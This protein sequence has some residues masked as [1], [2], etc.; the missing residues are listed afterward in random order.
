MYFAR[1]GCGCSA[2][3]LTCAV[4]QR[5]PSKADLRAPAWHFRPESGCARRDIIGDCSKLSFPA[6]SSVEGQYAD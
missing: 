6:R 2:G 3:A 4:Q 1:C 5:L